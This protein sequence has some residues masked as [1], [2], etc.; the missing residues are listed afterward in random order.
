MVINKKR[1]VSGGKR[2]DESNSLCYN[3]GMKRIG[4]T[5]GVLA[6]RHKNEMRGRHRMEESMAWG[7]D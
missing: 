5:S 3:P 4:S 6:V 1:E 7:S 2:E